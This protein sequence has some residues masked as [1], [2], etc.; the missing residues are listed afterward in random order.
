LLLS[1]EHGR[2]PD[3]LPDEILG[4]GLVRHHTEHAISHI[5]YGI[6]P[7]QEGVSEQEEVLL[8]RHD[9][10]GADRAVLFLGSVEDII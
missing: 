3:T 9:G 10:Q 5:V 7:T 1:L 6:V 2:G 4:G 8:V